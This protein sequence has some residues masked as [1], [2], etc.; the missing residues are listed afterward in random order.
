[1]F[2]LHA[3]REEVKRSRKVAG[4]GLTKK[5]S[6]GERGRR[7]SKKTRGIKRD[8]KEEEI[9]KNSSRKKNIQKKRSGD[10]EKKWQWKEA[11]WNCSQRKSVPC[12][13]R[14]QH[15]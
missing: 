15:V 3:K 7:K 6:Q 14:G 13:N 4:G 5:C 1:M 10:W 8:H 11:S 12:P 9:G 2:Y